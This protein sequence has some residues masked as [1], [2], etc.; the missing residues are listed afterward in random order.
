MSRIHQI[1]C[2]TPKQKKKKGRKTEKD[3][4][5]TLPRL[6]KKN[7]I[8]LENKKITRSPHIEKYFNEFDFS[9][10]GILYCLQDQIFIKFTTTRTTKTFSLNE[11]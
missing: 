11:H 2:R 4:A 5:S 6:K 7:A 1:W 3:H 10:Y 8:H 9:H